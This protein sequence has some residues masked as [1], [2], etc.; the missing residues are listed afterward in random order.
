MPSNHRQAVPSYLL[1][2]DETE[3]RFIVRL[4]F[5]AFMIE[6]T[7][8]GEMKGHVLLDDTGRFYEECEER[9]IGYLDAIKRH[10]DK[11][12]EWYR[13]MAPTMRGKSRNA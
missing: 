9:G 12:M 10:L 7:P 5:P 8:T 11:A 6:L 1:A 4:F 13:E 3:R 2:R